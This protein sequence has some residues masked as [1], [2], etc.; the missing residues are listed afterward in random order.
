MT[1][2][3]HYHLSLFQELNWEKLKILFFISIKKNLL[4]CVSFYDS[5]QSQM[6][7]ETKGNFCF[8][9]HILFL[10]FVHHIIIF[11]LSLRRVGN[12]CKFVK[13]LLFPS[14]SCTH[15]FP[16][17]LKMFW[18]HETVFASRNALQSQNEFHI[19]RCCDEV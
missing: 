19:S 4:I 17:Y 15:S 12:V 10:T 1:H 9:F 2:I 7:Q 5:F 16:R 6:S 3:S 18:W 11:S 14:K 13:L 8:K